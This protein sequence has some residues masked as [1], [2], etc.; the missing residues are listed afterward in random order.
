MMTSKLKLKAMFGFN[1]FRVCHIP[2]FI[3]IGASDVRVK[4]RAYPSGCEGTERPGP[5]RVNVEQLVVVLI[6]ILLMFGLT[7]M[8]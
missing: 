2:K 3:S 8:L 1:T 6:V 5:D 4:E 7:L